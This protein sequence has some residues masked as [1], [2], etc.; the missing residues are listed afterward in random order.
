MGP[1]RYWSKSAQMSADLKAMTKRARARRPEMFVA[2]EITTTSMDGE[3]KVSTTV[4]KDVRAAA[5]APKARH[6]LAYKRD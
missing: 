2:R 4:H 3:G 5:M 1:A 6:A